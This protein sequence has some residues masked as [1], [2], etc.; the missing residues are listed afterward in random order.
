MTVATLLDHRAIDS[1]TDAGVCHWSLLRGRQLG[2]T[3]MARRSSM[4]YALRS[5]LR[6]RYWRMSI[7]K[8]SPRWWPT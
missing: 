5:A 4:V 3:S 1:K 6:G 7:A 8:W 2:R